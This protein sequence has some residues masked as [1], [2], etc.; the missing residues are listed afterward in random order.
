MK[1]DGTFDVS[2]LWRRGEVGK[3]KE[4]N[5]EG[6]QLPQHVLLGK[7]RVWEVDYEEARKHEHNR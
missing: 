3:G 4:V 2:C 5:G 7:S 6:F 1:I